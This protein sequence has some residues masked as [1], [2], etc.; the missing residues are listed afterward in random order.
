MD[1][2]LPVQSGPDAAQSGPDAVQSGPDAAQQKPWRNCGFEV[3]PMP[4]RNLVI[5][6]QV[7]AERLNRFIGPHVRFSPGNWR[8][9]TDVAAAVRGYYGTVTTYLIGLYVT[10]HIFVEDWGREFD[11]FD[12]YVKEFLSGS[13][14]FQRYLTRT[15][16]PPRSA[17]FAPQRGQ[18]IRSQLLCE[19]ISPP[20]DRRGPPHPPQLMPR[21]TTR[22]W[23]EENVLNTPGCASCHDHIT[24]VGFA[25]EHFDKNGMYRTQENGHPIDARWVLHDI[26]GRTAE[27]DGP[28][29][30]M[31]VLANSCAV[32]Q[33]HAVKWLQWALWVRA[34]PQPRDQWAPLSPPDQS[35]AMNKIAGAFAASDGDLR[36]LVIAVTQSDAFLRP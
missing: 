34:T 20:R 25:F 1:A 17:T 26:D 6:P 7:V 13:G 27:G 36:E 31:E 30:L 12:A 28:G 4:V 19:E 2:M 8:T 23:F 9:T 10:P 29:A 16:G 14:G 32:P 11:A 22:R 15:S 33:C 21:T 3:A 24:R 18:A 35:E 5:S